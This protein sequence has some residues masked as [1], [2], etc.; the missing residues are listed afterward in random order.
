MSNSLFSALDTIS[1]KEY[2][3]VPFWSWNNEIK[4]EECKRQIRQMQE[5]GFGGFIIHARA[6]LKTEYLGEE[7]F[8]CVQACIDEAKKRDMCIWIYDEFGYPSGFVGGTLLEN[9]SHRAEYLEYELRSEFD[10]SAFAV[11]V[12]RNGGYV[13]IEKA[14]DADCYH[15]VYKRRSPCNVDILNPDMVGLFLEKTYEAYYKRFADEFGKTIRGFFT[16]EP[17]Y[18]RYATPYTSILE[19]EIENVKDGL[20]HL[21]GSEESDYGMPEPPIRKGSLKAA[22]DEIP[23]E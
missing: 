2:A 12:Q 18:Y 7:W 3:P 5:V 21:F 14:T 23:F 4:P 10:E 9:E 22:D 16:D 19:S 15:T 17:Q 11:Y 6:G 13:R 8:A 1:L 20:I